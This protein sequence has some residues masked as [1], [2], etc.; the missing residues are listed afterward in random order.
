MTTDDVLEM[1]EYQEEYTT[2]FAADEETA[3]WVACAEHELEQRR[4]EDAASDLAIAAQLQMDELQQA[5][6][7]W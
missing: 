3:A 1:M 6:A 2:Q 4:E 7:H 5:P